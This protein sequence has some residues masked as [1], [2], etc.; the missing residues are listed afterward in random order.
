MP[1]QR[2]LGLIVLVGLLL[3]GIVG[4]LGNLLAQESAQRMADDCPPP[5]G[6]SRPVT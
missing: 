2:K 5:A 3:F 4:L 6:G 1:L